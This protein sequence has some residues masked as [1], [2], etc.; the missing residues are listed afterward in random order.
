MVIKQFNNLGNP[1]L[2]E[3]YFFTDEEAQTAREKLDGFRLDFSSE[4]SISLYAKGIN[5]YSIENSD[6]KT[7][8]ISQLDP[9][10]RL[11]DLADTFGDYGHILNI[12]IP[13]EIKSSKIKDYFNEKSSQIESSSSKSE[14]MFRLS[15]EYIDELRLLPH[16]NTNKKDLLSLNKNYKVVT[17]L[18]SNFKNNLTNQQL[19]EKSRSDALLKIK[20]LLQQIYPTK[21]VNSLI[22]DVISEAGVILNNSNNQQ[23]INPVTDILHLSHESISKAYEKITSN[24]SR[25]IQTHKEKVDKMI[26]PLEPDQIPINLFNQINYKTNSNEINRTLLKES[27]YEATNSKSTLIKNGKILIY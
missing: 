18:I 2:V 22:N 4:N 19:T 25:L 1:C 7:I 10:I 8:A 26:A 11:E 20:F 16:T 3:V 21:I 17:Q 13:M 14:Q 12:E 15:D 5:D 6:S 27:H 9:K 24:L 23:D